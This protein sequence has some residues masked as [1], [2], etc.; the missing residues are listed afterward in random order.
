MLNLMKKNKI[1]Y[2]PPQIGVIVVTIENCISS[3]SQTII[4]GNNNGEIT[5]T[6]EEEIKSGTT[7]W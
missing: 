6:W 2:V 4:M 3:T 5:E 7:I 1:K